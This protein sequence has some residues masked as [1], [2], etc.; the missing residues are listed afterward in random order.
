MPTGHLRHYLEHYFAP[1]PSKEVRE[2]FASTAILDFAVS[3]VMVFEPIYLFKIGFT[4]PQILLFFAALYVLYFFALPI[5]GRICRRHGYEHSIL[6]SSPFLILYYISLYA[7]QWDRR[8]LVV[9]LFALVVQKILYWPGYHANLA[10]HGDG[11]EGGREVSNMY[12]VAGIASALGPLFGGAIIAWGGFQTLFL[13]VAGLII[14]SNLPLWSSPEL[15]EPHPFPYGAALARVFK[16]ETRRQAVGFA[17]YGE[18]LFALT[19]WP[20]FIALTVQGYVAAGVVLSLSMLLTVLV[21]LYIGRMADEDGRERVMRSGVVYVVASWLIRPLVSGGLGAFLADA[22]YRVSKNTAAVPM[23]AM[24]YDGAR[25][26]HVMAS[27]IFFEMSLSAG[28]ALAALL[29]ALIFWKLPSA[30][31]WPAAFILAAVFASLFMLIREE[32]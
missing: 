4:V 5:G 23:T 15:F 7:L 28:K 6:Y 10:L 24:I 11:Q 16:P 21:T 18:E 13:V 3:S 17:G 8:L 30:A 14:V 12:A 19:I 1:H 22:F 20:L 2:M 25:R 9:A 31:A 26:N 29:G 32:K 27:V